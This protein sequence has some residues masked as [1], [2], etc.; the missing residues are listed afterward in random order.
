MIGDV[1]FKDAVNAIIPLLKETFP[2]DRFFAAEASGR[3]AFAPAIQ[4][5]I[6]MLATNN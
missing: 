3:I 5:I 1:K 2:R 6:N 4:P